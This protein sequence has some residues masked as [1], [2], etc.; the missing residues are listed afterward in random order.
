[1]MEFTPFSLPLKEVSLYRN[2]SSLHSFI[3]VG[4]QT[5]SQ[6]LYWTPPYVRA[7]RKIKIYVDLVSA[8][9]PLYACPALGEEGD[10]E[11]DSEDEEV[12]GE[13]LVV[14]HDLPLELLKMI[15]DKVTAIERD[16]EK[17]K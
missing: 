16:I 14:S 7:Q 1:M 2:F 17:D 15:E 8:L 4:C 12:D 9:P 13:D 11:E 5:I 10:T 3:F 6:G